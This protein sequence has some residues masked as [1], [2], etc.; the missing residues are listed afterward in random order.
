MNF[1]HKK[2]FPQILLEETFFLHFKLKFYLL[3]FHTRINPY[4]EQSPN[5][6]WPFFQRD[7]S[8]QQLKQL[9][10]TVNLFNFHPFPIKLGEVQAEDQTFGPLKVGQKEN[11]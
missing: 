3:D 9:A 1:Q 5:Q 10:F 6:F 4:D 11:G 2:Y 7:L 8:L